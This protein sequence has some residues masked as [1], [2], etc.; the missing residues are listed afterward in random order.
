M[1]LSR[2][3][4][5]REFTASQAADRLGFD[6]TPSDLHVDAMRLLCAEI[7]EPIR[8][9]FGPVR[10]TSGYRSP[11]VNRAI[12]GSWTS[13]HRKGQAAD[14][15]IPGVD[16]LDVAYWC[17]DHLHTF[18]QLISEY[19]R[20]G[21]P[22]SGWIHISHRSDGKNRGEVLTK[23]SKVRGYIHGLPEQGF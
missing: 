1:H 18:D 2:H 22:S 23:N 11:E 17:R 19:Y 9:H 20:D 7:L 13:Q 6:N 5:L 16:N 12:G 3:F 4:T 21:D 14:F 15:E 8:D 10:I